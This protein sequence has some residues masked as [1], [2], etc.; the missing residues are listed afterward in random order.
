[1]PKTPRFGTYR[2]PA[3]WEPQKSTWIAWP[4]NEKDWPGKFAEIPWVFS[5]IIS[6][7]S[8]IQSVNVLV[9]NKSEREKAVFFLNILDAK[10]KN[11]KFVIC[12]TDRA[13]T[14]DF[15]PIFLKDKKNRNVLSNWEFN[16]WSKYKNF[17]NDNRAYI[18]I[19]EFKKIKSI[20]PIHKRKKI[21][22][23]GGSID[24]NGKGLILTT[25][26]CLLSKVQQRNKGFKI[27][28]YNQIFN[29]Y[30][31][32]RKVIWLNKGI[33]GDDTH[34]HIDD[35]A[36]FIDKNKIFIAREKNRKDKNYLNLSENIKILK[37]F[38]KN[39]K[40]K[41]K[42][43]Y[44]PMPQPKYID[45][46]RVPASYLNFYIANKIVLVPTFDD[47]NDKFVLG[48]FKKYFKNRKVI[49]MNCSELV[50]GL[51]TLHCMTQQEPI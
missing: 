24:V 18:K 14:R 22:L 11:I 4:H 44:L 25:K 10:I 9:K 47:S 15:L 34:G 8:K 41:I 2:M 48:I 33:Y 38:I 49:P 43:I 23:E 19:K 30:F 3:E 6:I 7:L 36:R 12:K 42:I 32:A 26:Q 39:N 27:E 5:K 20:K 29:K 21:V 35:I 37:K 31:G 17:R 28:D 45:G 40:E 1:M 51:G 16:A 46:I 50:W 13:W